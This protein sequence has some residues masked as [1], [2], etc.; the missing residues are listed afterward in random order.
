MFGS[1]AIVSQW[2]LAVELVMHILCRNMRPDIVTQTVSNLPQQGVIAL[3]AFVAA[4]VEGI[5]H[6]ITLDIK[7]SVAAF[8]APLL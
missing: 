1:D 3:V 7:K 8:Q 4:I 2:Y 6:V 5:I